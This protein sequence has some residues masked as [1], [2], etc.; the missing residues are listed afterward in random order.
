MKKEKIFRAVYL[1]FITLFALSGCNAQQSKTKYIENYE[2]YGSN[3]DYDLF[4]NKKITVGMWV[5]PPDHLRNDESFKMIAESGINMV[6]GFPYY[7]NTEEEIIE[8]LTYCEKYHL[9]YLLASLEIENDIRK[10]SQ[11]KDSSHI[12]HTMSIID[13]Y[14]NYKAFAG[15]LFIDEPDS[16]LLDAIGDFFK[17][18]K[19]KYPN[20]IAYV[21]LF[22]TYAVAGTG[23]SRYEDYV[24]NWFSKTHAKLL[25]YDHY[26]LIETDPSQEGYLYEYQDYYY[27]LDILRQKTLD[28]GVPLW[29]FVATLGYEHPSEYT[30]REPTREDIRWTVFS[31]LAFGAKAIQYFCYFTPTQDSFQEAMVTRG[32]SK[33]PRYDYVKEVN[34]EFQSYESIL[35]NA[36]A[37]GVMM[38]DYRRNGYYLYAEPL[39][40]FGPIR[41]VEGNRYLIGCFQD[42]DIGNKSV[43]ITPTTPRDDISIVLNLYDNITEVDAYIQGKKETL[44][45]KN[46]KLPLEIAKG[47]SVFLTFK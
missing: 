42:K 1:P 27:S 5:T 33:T 19:E 45:V 15:T 6:N 17:I 40:S 36:D 13:K 35:M 16:S 12:D 20:K 29:T 28:Q 30:R 25:S 47:D 14:A 10:Y 26:P 38:N 3:A 34:K 2:L 41:S 37:V 32:G 11:D 21:N 9:N 4:N 31:N 8:V 39:S 44:T 24:D 22:P 7:E 18:Y 46:G 23:Y 43:M